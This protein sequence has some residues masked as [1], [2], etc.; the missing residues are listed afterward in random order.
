MTHW[1]RLSA[2]RMIALVAAALLCAG[3]LAQGPGPGDIIDEFDDWPHLETISESATV[4]A[5][6]E[7]GLGALKK[8]RGAWGFKESERLSGELLGR[9]WRVRDGYTS[10]EVLEEL[11]GAFAQAGASLLFACDGRGCGSGAQWA[12]RVFGQ[13]LLYGREDLQR[14]RVYSV[15]GAGGKQG[16]GGATRV[17]MFAAARSS[18]RQYLHV[19]MLTPAD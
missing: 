17:L 10:Q 12:N 7:I 1:A 9:T 5:D 13:R 4:V 6:H 16:A 8:V 18:E 11:E 14:Y 2:G 19:E 15:P 3:P